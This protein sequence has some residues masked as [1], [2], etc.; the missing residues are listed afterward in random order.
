MTDKLKDDTWMWVIVQDPSGN[1]QFLGQHDDEKDVSFIPAFDEKDI[2]Q[3]AV[4]K[5]ITEIEELNTKPRPSCLK[6]LP[7]MPPSMDF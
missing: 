6:N 1:E 3:R 2:A 4:G 5:F 7:K